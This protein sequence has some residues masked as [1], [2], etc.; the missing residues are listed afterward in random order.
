MNLN[1]GK[2]GKTQRFGGG[3][4]G[5]RESLEKGAAPVENRN[6]TGLFGKI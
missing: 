6:V 5:L 3:R 2:S 1:L 4:G